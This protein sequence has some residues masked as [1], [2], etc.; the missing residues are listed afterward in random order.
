MSDKRSHGRKNKIIGSDF[1]EKELQK[2]FEDAMDNAKLLSNDDQ[3]TSP[4]SCLIYTGSY[5][6]GY[7]SLSRGHA[8]S[9]I[10]LHIISAWKTHGRFPQEKECVSHLCHRKGCIK[11]SH[12]IIESLK[13]NNERVGC[14]HAFKD[15]LSKIWN[16]CRHDPRCLLPD[17]ENTKG[18]KPTLI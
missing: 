12:L 5:Q 17:E 15:D 6:N 8:K 13:M 11:P 2:I 9:K 14:L 3:V 7:P 10:K 4:S 18:F 16:L 1:Q